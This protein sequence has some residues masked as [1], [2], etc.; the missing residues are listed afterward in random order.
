[1]KTR[2]EAFKAIEKIV[3]QLE[4]THSKECGK[5]RLI[6]LLGAKKNESMSYGKMILLDFLLLNLPKPVCFCTNGKR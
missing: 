6:L 5:K 3:F 4:K 1:M 2:S